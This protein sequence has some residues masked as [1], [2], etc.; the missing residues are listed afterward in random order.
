ML[1]L[2]IV[3]RPPLSLSRRR[4]LVELVKRQHTLHRLP[5]CAALIGTDG[6]DVGAPVRIL[7]DSPLKC[8]LI[9]ELAGI[10]PK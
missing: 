7:F 2:F 6:T 3:G 1:K 9:A 5:K 4:Q 8:D 10:L